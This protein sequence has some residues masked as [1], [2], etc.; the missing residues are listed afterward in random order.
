MVADNAKVG[1]EGKNES[2]FWGGAPTVIDISDHRI[3]IICSD[4]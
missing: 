3:A 1:K 2:S 4:T